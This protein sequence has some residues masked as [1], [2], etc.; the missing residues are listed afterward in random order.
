[1]HDQN[2]AQNKLRFGSVRFGSRFGSRLPQCI[3]EGWNDA[4]KAMSLVGDRFF[5]LDGTVLLRLAHPVTRVRVH[6]V[7][8]PAYRDTRVL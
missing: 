4:A 6:K 5:L 7:E 1:M 2:A 8:R 3:D